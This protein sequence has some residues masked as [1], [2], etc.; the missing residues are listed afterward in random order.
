MSNRPE[1]KMTDFRSVQWENTRVSKSWNTQTSIANYA[2]DI[3]VIFSLEYAT[4]SN[5]HTDDIMV[6]QHAHRHWFIDWILNFPR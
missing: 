3:V 4:T 2:Y 1:I 6:Q 5:I